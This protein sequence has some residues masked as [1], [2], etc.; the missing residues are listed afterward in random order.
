MLDILIHI[1]AILDDMTEE[2]DRLSRHQTS[3]ASGIARR[4]QRIRGE[5]RKL[6]GET[7]EWRLPSD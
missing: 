2:M 5:I 1:L 4:I 6:E 7:P 3:G